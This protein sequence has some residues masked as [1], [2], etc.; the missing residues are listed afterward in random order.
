MKY[1]VE[2]NQI[3]IG[4]EIAVNQKLYPDNYTK[5][6]FEWHSSN[7]D[8]IEIIEGKIVG[9]SVGKAEI[10]LT[11]NKICSNKIEIEC[12]INIKDILIQ[13]QVESLKLGDI[14]KLETSIVPENATYKELIFESSNLDIATVDNDGNIIANAIGET[15]IT[16]KDYKETELK[17][18][19]INIMKIPVTE[20]TLDDK[21]VIL[22]KGQE[23]IINSKVTPVEA[24]YT[25]VEWESSDESVVTIKNRKIKAISSGTAKITA[26]TD[27]GE[28]K[29]VCKITVTKEKP[30]N[31]KLFAKGKYNIRNGASTDYSILA[32]TTQYEQIEFLQDTKN[33]WKKVRN[34]KG[35]VGY[36]L[37]KS[38][39]YLEEK[40]V[41]NT[42]GNAEEPDNIVTS[43]HIKEVPYLN[44]I[45]LG[46]PTGCEAVSATMV[47][48]YKGYKVSVKNIIDNTK[49]G[50]K[51]YKGNDGNWYG[52]NPFE[53]FVG[54]P[55]L[56]LGKGS[57]GVFAKPIASAMSNY[58][59]GKVK[60]IS[61]CS[62]KA[63]LN[64]VSKGNPVV[65]WCVKNGGNLKNGVVWTY[66]D[67]SGT[68]QELIGEHCAVLIGYDE[69]YVYLNDPSA[70][71]NVKQSRSKFMSN[72]K[73]LYQQAIVVE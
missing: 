21:E 42:A 33:G 15:T 36:T 56:G 72:W 30:K 23:Y 52:G 9:K 40:P 17:S 16:V 2:K 38:G 18:F 44:Q 61:G 67:Q 22:G 39:Y 71:Q 20:I 12:L 50:S 14:Y 66:E 59:G 47:L 69:D 24:T 10:Y 46:Y 55:N 57:Y 5:S 51:K 43:Y 63:L 8:I 65:V 45:S 1:G 28:K 6:N 26:I 27:E 29:A 73:K 19:N 70:G 49:S 37:V 41:E 48:K 31:K 34:E 68:F 60:N 35:V 32:T 13:N 3:E 25:D 54:R 58:A 4:E 11:D 62:E 64:H 7:T 53:E